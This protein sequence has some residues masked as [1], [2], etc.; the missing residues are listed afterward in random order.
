[1]TSYS[2]SWNHP[3]LLSSATHPKPVQN[4]N[5][6]LP[7]WQSIKKGNERCKIYHGAAFGEVDKVGFQ[8]G[9][10]V[11]IIR[12]PPVDSEFLYELL[13]VALDGAMGLSSFF[14]MFLAH[15]VTFQ[16]R[17]FLLLWVFSAKY[18]CYLVVAMAK[19]DF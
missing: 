1:M 9:L 17:K 3:L 14:C 7:F 18:P 13:D 19:P 8:V 6:R 12:A 16:Y 10:L 2:S 11:G 4:F 15:W 5:T